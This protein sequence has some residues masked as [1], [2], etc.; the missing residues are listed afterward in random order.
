MF[1]GALA[2]FHVIDSNPLLLR[3]PRL[4]R[5]LRQ[6]QFWHLHFALRFLK[7]RWPLSIAT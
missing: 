1:G 6:V 5:G 7:I 2:G 3:G 4:R